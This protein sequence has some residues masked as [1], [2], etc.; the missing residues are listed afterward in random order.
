MVYHTITE[1]IVKPMLTQSL[2]LIKTSGTEYTIKGYVQMVSSISAMFKD[3]GIFESY[4]VRGFFLPYYEIGDETIVVE[5][6]DRIKL[7]DGTS[8]VV[9]RVFKHYYENKEIYR[10]VLLEGM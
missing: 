7:S 2:T 8:Y 5:Q 1:K 6:N 4:D 3:V 10:E 9:T